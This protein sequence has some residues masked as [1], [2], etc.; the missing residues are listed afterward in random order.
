M[1]YGYTEPPC[2]K[3]C[4]PCAVLRDPCHICGIEL[5]PPPSHGLTRLRPPAVD[6]DETAY[7]TGRD[8]QAL[9][10]QIDAPFTADNGYARRIVMYSEARRRRMIPWVGRNG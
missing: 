6:L 9:A 10:L 7:E 1:P 3:H 5:P 2:R 4:D 8:L